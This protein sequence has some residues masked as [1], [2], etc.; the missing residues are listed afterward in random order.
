MK[1]TLLGEVNKAIFALLDAK[2]DKQLNMQV[3]E[4]AKTLM[5]AQYGKLF[6]Y[7]KDRLK[8][9]YSSSRDIKRSP[10]IRNKNV[11]KLLNTKTIEY[12]SQKKLQMWQ[13]KNIPSEITEIVLVPLLHPQQ[14][15]GFLFLYFSN[16]KQRMTEFE[17]ETITLFS[18]AAV[19]ALTKAKLQEESQKAL[20]IR[21]R[22]IS[23]SSH[24]LRTPLTSIHG[25]IQLLYARLKDKDT[26]ESRWVKE[27]YIESIRM[28]TLV[29]ELLDVNRIKQGQFA[30]V[31]SEVPMLE[32]TT[33]ALERHRVTDAN[34]PF[35]FQ[36][37]LTKTQSIVVGD[38]DKLVEMVSGLLG[39]A[40]KFSKPGEKITV[41]LKNNQGMVSLSVKDTG[42]GISK[43]D[44]DAIFD[45]FYKATHASHIE[46]M[47]VGL[48][49]A[50]HIIDNHRGKLKI[51]SKENK[52]TTV[53]VS[54][55][56][57]KTTKD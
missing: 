26:V 27:L 43:Q 28:T 30:F 53:S 20:D 19:L 41:L 8:K 51:T 24:E 21:D 44:I 29:K 45:G 10:L 47:G 6:F 49:L 40:V 33:K 2:S 50:R 48:L 34:H 15:L 18:R 56:T 32:V 14:P 37:K 54:L 35:E 42:R 25:Y 7:N 31:F 17:Q 12:I 23:L 52:G 9:V 13:I 46:G 36:S 38:F 39:N 22:F 55:P 5:K 3:V 4:T 16:R 57:I 1:S 11:K